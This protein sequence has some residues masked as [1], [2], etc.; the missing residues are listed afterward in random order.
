MTFQQFI[1]GLAVSLLI[2]VVIIAGLLAATGLILKNGAQKAMQPVEQA[3]NYLSTQ[4]TNVLHPTPTVIPDPVT[5]L[6]EVRSLARLE[7]VQYSMEKVITTE[8]GQGA[9]GFLFGD[10]LLFVAHGEVIAG[11]DLEKLGADQMWVENGVL[12]VRLP[13]AEIFVA[14]LD[15]QLSYVYDRETGILKRGDVTL[16]SLARKAA[17]D[18][19]EKAAVADG[20]LDTAQ[21]NA[22]S[23]LYRLLRQLGFQE[24]IFVHE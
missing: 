11:I 13:E 22:E 21:K 6:R 12:M 4:V 5:I 1:K 20:I 3:S 16:E 14:T 19:I 15:N 23:Y 9:L 17:E 18:E 2:L 7:T 10:R 8:V 24:V